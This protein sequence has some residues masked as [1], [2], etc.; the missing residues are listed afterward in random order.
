M[1]NTKRRLEAVS[2]YDHTGIEKHLKQMA[3][4]GWMIEEISS[5]GWIY[6]R[7]EPKHGHFSVT[8]YPKASEF[9]PEPTEGQR[10]YQEFTA[11][12][13]WQFICSS[14]Q[15]Q[16]FYTEQEDPTPIETDPVTQ[17]ENIHKAAKK[18]HL[19]AYF[20]YLA[21]GV[22]NG[23]LFVSRLLGD[24][25]GTLASYSQLF[26]GVVWSLLLLLSL[27]ELTKYFLWYRKAKKAAE[28]GEFT[29]TPNN[30]RMQMFILW[31]VVLCFAYWIIN[32][33]TVGSVMTRWVSILVYGYIIALF[34]MVNGVKQLL[35]RRKVSKGTNLTITLIVDFVLAFAMMGA[36]TFGTLWAS[37]NGFFDRDAETY[38]YHGSTFILY[39]D[40]LPLTV[41]DMLNVEYDGYVR[42]RRSEESIFLG[43]LEANQ[44]SRFDDEEGRIH[45]GLDYTVAL[46][47]APFLYEMCKERLIGEKDESADSSV[48]EGFKRVYRSIDPAPWGAVEAYQLAYQDTGALERY[49]LCYEDRIVEISF[50]WEPTEQ[51][52]ATVGEKLGGR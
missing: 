49:L 22:L 25:I 31:T 45:P 18:N 41:E 48:P 5:L 43:M 36:I 3:E 14:A 20:L 9:D 46:I 32:V 44:W 4:K 12:S 23:V 10:M 2:L 19:L 39:Q 6:R 15:M 50:D 13:G 37:R 11:H 35:K 1:R 17:V 27:S 34:L 16:V 33:M 26:T 28:R 51:H 8:Y 40:Q 7:G 29:D 38:E 24:P 42:Q 30:K 52:K 47:K 21:I